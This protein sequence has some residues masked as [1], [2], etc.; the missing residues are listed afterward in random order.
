LPNPFGDQIIGVGEALFIKDKYFISDN[1]YAIIRANFN[2]KLPCL[3]EMKSYR[4]QL[5]AGFEY[6][7]INDENIKFVDIKQQIKKR[8]FEFLPTLTPDELRDINELRIKFT[9]D[10]TN[11]GKNLSLLNFC[12]TFLE[13]KSVFGNFTIGV[14]EKL[15]KNTEL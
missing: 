12:F 7:T 9:A 1:S 14:K 5:N 11:V 8:L 15:K 4:K 2:S 13:D 3:N 6:F 10:G